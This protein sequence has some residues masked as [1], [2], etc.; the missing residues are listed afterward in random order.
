MKKVQSFVV[1]TTQHRGVFA[2]V[3][4][5]KKDE[6]T[7]TLADA[8]MCVYWSADV[9][10][11]LGLATSGPSKT[12]KVTRQVPQIVLQDVTSVIDCT[13]EAEEAWRARPWN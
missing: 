10:G 5:G 1:V 3:L 4:T 12:C 6:K 8:Q 2:G 11:V 13:K 7:V 9:Q